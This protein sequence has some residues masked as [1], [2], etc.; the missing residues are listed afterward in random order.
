[1]DKNTHLHIRYPSRLIRPMDQCA[2]IAQL[3]RSAWV[4]RTIEREILTTLGPALG[5]DVTKLMK[6]ISGK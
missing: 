1:M 6:E 4:R 3:S 5:K 2:K